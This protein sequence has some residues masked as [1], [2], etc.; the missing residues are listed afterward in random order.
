M[1]RAR[2]GKGGSKP[3][4]VSGNPHVFSEAAARKKGGKVV[5]MAG[6]KAKRRFD[7]PGRKSGGRVGANTS[8][9]STAHNV[10]SSA[11]G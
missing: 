9:L 8:P 1:S 2:H 4:K 5:S 10:T 6:D 3:M 7:K 11:K